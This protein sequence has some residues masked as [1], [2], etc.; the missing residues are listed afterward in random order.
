VSEAPGISVLC[1]TR[2]RPEN[3]RRLVSTGVATA[4]GPVEFVFR[5][6]DDAPGSVPGDVAAR[7][8]VTVVEGP[9]IV[10]SDLWNECWREASAEVFMQC[11]D[12]IAFRTPGWDA[13][14]LAEFG[15]HPD[16]IVFVHGLDGLRE[17]TWGSHGF[18]HRR[19]TDITGYFTPPYFSCDYSDTWLNELANRAGRRVLVDILTEHLH[20]NAGKHPWDQVHADR[21]ARGLRDGVEALY[22]SLEPERE[23]DAAKL[24]AAMS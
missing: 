12:D 2:N 5:C 7:D 21:A 15:R 13:I 16:R 14:V 23:R 3:V 1:P 4:A 19:W 8:D 6:D 24:M 10:M 9:R 11:G 20:P 22:A 18:L 17:N